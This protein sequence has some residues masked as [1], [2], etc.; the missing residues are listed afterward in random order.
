MVR[1][2]TL[3]KHNHCEEVFLIQGRTKIGITALQGGGR[4]EEEKAQK[5][6]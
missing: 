6:T 3:T 4:V 5:V 2:E 1:K